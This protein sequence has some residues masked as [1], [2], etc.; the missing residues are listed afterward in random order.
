MILRS[1]GWFDFL[2]LWFPF[3]FRATQKFLNQLQV[4]AE[5]HNFFNPGFTPQEMDE[6]PD[7]YRSVIND[8]AFLHDAFVNAH[9][10]MQQWLPWFKLKVVCPDRSWFLGEEDGSSGLVVS[11][12]EKTESRFVSEQQY[13]KKS[14]DFFRKVVRKLFCL[15]GLVAVFITVSA[16]QSCHTRSTSWSIL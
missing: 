15:F 10:M 9:G 2:E 1:S 11:V 7:L 8:P 6:L 3:T 12:S 16:E 14:G 13:V 5:S 4:V